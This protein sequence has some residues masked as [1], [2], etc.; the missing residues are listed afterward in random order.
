MFR[1]PEKI[2]PI[3]QKME[4][5]PSKTSQGLLYTKS[6]IRN[7]TRRPFLAG[8]WGVDTGG[9]LYFAWKCPPLSKQLKEQTDP[10]FVGCSAVGRH[11]LQADGKAMTEV[12]LKDRCRALEQELAA[13]R[14]VG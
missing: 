4:A 11:S 2:S 3:G 10:R 12:D 14:E 1:S 6:V 7:R 5:F 8:F 13:R 9:L